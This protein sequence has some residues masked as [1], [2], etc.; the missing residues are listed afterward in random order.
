MDLFDD[1]LAI[2]VAEA[3]AQFF[4]VHGRLVLFL[5]PHLCHRCRLKDFE[6]IVFLLGPLDQVR[7]FNVDEKFK[8]E[9]P[10]LDGTITFRY[11]E[12]QINK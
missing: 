9:L 2:I 8:K 1:T 6:L 7:A 10:E 3:T 12:K 5:A 4:V 11:K